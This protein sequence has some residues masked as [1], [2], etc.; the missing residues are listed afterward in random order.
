MIGR[1]LA[2]YEITHLIGRGGMGEVYRARDTRLGREVALKLLPQAFSSDPERVARLQ[3]EARTLAS[4]HHPNIASVFGIE[5]AEGQTLLVMELVEGEDLAQRLSRGPIALD[6]ALDI[7]R[8]IAQGLEEAHAKGIVHRD[9]KPANVKLAPGGKVKILDFGLARAILGDAAGDLGVQ[10]SP[11]ITAAM[12]QAGVI[13]GTAAYMSPEQA[14]GKEVDKRADIW[15]FGVILFEMLSGRQL[16]DGE[17]T[18]DVLAA[19]VTRDPDWN[20]LPAEVTPEVRRLLHRCLERDV[21]RRLRDAGDALLDLDPASTTTTTTATAAAAGA[22]PAASGA[23]RGRRVYAAAAGLA[24]VAAAI[25]FVAGKREPASSPQAAPVVRRLQIAD[26]YF[27]QNSNA[28]IS[29]DGQRIIYYDTRKSPP[30]LVLRPLDT[31][32]QTPVHEGG[33][34]PFFAPDGQSFGFFSDKKLWVASIAGGT[35]RTLCTSDGFATGWW[36][37]DDT[38][39]FS[40]DFEPDQE[41]EGLMRIAAQ[42]GEPQWLSTVDR[43]RSE[44]LHAYPQ[45]LPGGKHVLFTVVR[46][47][48]WEVDVVPLAGGERRAI[49]QNAARGRYVPSGHLLYVDPAQDALMAVAFDL[50]RLEVRGSPVSLVRDLRHTGEGLGAYDISNDGTLIYSI[51]GIMLGQNHIVAVDR[52]GRVRPLL[53]EASTWAQPHISPDGGRLLVRRAGQPDCHLW[54][55]DL[56]RRALTRLTFEGDNHGPMWTDGGNTITFSRA[57]SAALIRTPMRQVV[58]GGVPPSVLFTPPHPMV[59][60]SSTRDGRWLALTRE[61]RTD[62]NEVWIYDTANP[63][64]PEPFLQSSFSEDW[65]AFSPDGRL[66]AYTSDE[67]GRNEIYVRAFPGP[68]G[69]LQISTEGG[70]GALWSHRG[71]ELFYAAGSKMMRVAM[72]TSPTLSAGVPEVLF[73]GEFAWERPRNYDISPDGQTF[74]MLRPVGG[75]TDRAGLIVVVDWFEEL[76]RAVPVR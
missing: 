5:E 10:N 61:D 67:T 45:V 6:D 7:A 9:L 3:R 23:S 52:V 73:E 22:P 44:R 13:L 11:T 37:E 38:I 8:Q 46:A 75:V 24:L 31:F 71:D 15:A 49:L 26:A 40:T 39:V 36:G 43:S 57:T 29:P 25:G 68:G 76:R 19:V 16:Y 14:R 35:P 4:L 72:R 41:K 48:G 63:K 59:A 56:E 21:R 60:Q 74:Y 34:N 32:E 17:T 65:P 70:Q 42:G 33:F 27:D 50:Q 58:D 20:Q 55:F 28:A 69:K 18:T 12:T 53:E 51:S 62:R 54:L 64:P 47:D 2:H 66:I 30:R 1:T